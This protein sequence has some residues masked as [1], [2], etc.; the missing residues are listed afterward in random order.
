[1]NL[2][3][4]QDES[5]D[6]AVYP[7]IDTYGGLIYAVLGLNGE[8]GEIAEQVKKSLRDDDGIL[9]RERHDALVKELGDVLWYLAAVATELQIDLNDVASENL[10]KLR[11]R[12]ERNL[13]H[14]AGDDR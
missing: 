10:I 2:N 4:Y 6:T 8:A 14:G 12:K 3:E 7:G 11:S 9:T 5:R 1:V 13:I